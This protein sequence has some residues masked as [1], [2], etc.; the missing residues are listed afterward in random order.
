MP[1][2][3]KRAL[4]EE[5][6]RLN[7][8][9]NKRFKSGRKELYEFDNIGYHQDY[10]HSIHR[11]IP[12]NLDQLQRVVAKEIGS[13]LNGKGGILCFGCRTNGTVYGESL[14]RWEEDKMK[15]VIDDVFK[16]FRPMVEPQRYRVTCTHVSRRY[17]TPDTSRTVVEIRVQAGDDHEMYEDIY[18]KT[19]LRKGD[20][21]YGPLTPHE[22]KRLTTQQLR[23]KFQALGPIQS[24]LLCPTREIPKQ[25]AKTHPN[26]ATEKTKFHIRIR[27]RKESSGSEEDP[28]LV[29]IVKPVVQIHREQR[30]TEEVAVE[31]KKE[32]GAVIDLTDDGE[33][34]DGKILDETRDENST[35]VSSN[36]HRSSLPSGRALHSK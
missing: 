19:Y 27:H 2:V 22:I 26:K 24:T 5:D 35:P 14:P 7:A 12:E 10:F 17:W 25:T 20:A 30:M 18:H 16:R 32:E 29:A 9:T 23:Q 34:E 6:N 28:I 36:G 31:V 1:I 15:L 4:S 13:F 11:L 21:P 3:R 33:V 8:P